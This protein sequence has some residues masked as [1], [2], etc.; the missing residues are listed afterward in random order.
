MVEDGLHVE[1][2]A[3]H[4]ATYRR[5]EPVV[6]VRGWR[7]GDT[8]L[9]VPPGCYEKFV[10]LDDVIKREVASSRGPGAWWVVGHRSVAVCVQLSYRLGGKKVP[11]GRRGSQQVSSGTRCLESYF[12]VQ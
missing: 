10:V 4:T 7:S 8:A 2:I 9:H 11:N 5:E 3:I 12:S 6:V 1:G